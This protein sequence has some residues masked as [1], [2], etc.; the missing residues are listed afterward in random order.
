MIEVVR[1]S[2]KSGGVWHPPGS[3]LTLDECE[4]TRLIGLGFAK[5]IAPPA[6][7]AAERETPADEPAPEP[8]C[9]APPDEP[10]PAESDDIGAAI[11]TPAKPR[12]ARAKKGA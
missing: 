3:R 11:V 2:V 5:P 7:A 9:E 12:K 8:E 1:G 6:P 10:A 4:E